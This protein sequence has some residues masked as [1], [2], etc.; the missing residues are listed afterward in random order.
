MNYGTFYGDYE[1]RARIQL[2]VRIQPLYHVGSYAEGTL[3]LIIY[4]FL[5]IVR[6]SSAFNSK[7][8]LYDSLLRHYPDLNSQ[9]ISAFVV[10]CFYGWRIQ[11]LT[12]LRLLSACIYLLATVQLRKILCLSL[13][14]SF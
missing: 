13:S 2:I 14:D 12:G 9:G 8:S 7:S 5:D 11:V 4:W 3:N 1:R 10:E 6:S